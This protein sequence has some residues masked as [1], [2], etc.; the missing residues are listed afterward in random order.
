LSTIILSCFLGCLFST[1]GLTSSFLGCVIDF[2]FIFSFSSIFFSSTTSLF[3]VALA[4]FNSFFNCSISLSR[5]F[6]S[7]D[8]FFFA[9]N[10]TSNFSSSA[11][12]FSS[13]STFFRSRAFL[14]LASDVSRPLRRFSLSLSFWASV[15]WRF[16]FF[17]G[18]SSIGASS[19][20]Y[21]GSSSSIFIST[22][23]SSASNTSLF[24]FSAIYIY[25]TKKNL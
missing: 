15:S 10:A 4:S 2:S 12:I 1:L 21:S 22:I 8:L 25:Y 17:F 18:G 20:F 7:L 14:L 11:V 3:L 13:C 9:C 23:T 6:F 24:S 19:S 16:F 5:S